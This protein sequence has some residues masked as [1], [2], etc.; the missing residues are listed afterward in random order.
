MFRSRRLL[1]KERSKSK[2][3]FIFIIFVIFLLVAIGVEFLYFSFGKVTLVSPLAIIRTSKIVI[4]ESSLQK[5]QIH[6]STVTV[7][8]DG[9]YMVKLTDEGEVILSSKKD[10]GSQLSSLQLMLSRLTIEG[11]KLKIL[12]FRF[13]NPIVSF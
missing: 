12:D 3:K 9:S 1:K 5:Q 7:N 13:D 11:K 4:L 2:L 8:N 10:I 6:F